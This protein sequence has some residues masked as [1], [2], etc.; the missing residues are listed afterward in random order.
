LAKS[1]GSLVPVF[2]ANF[3]RRKKVFSSVKEH[4]EREGE[5]RK[6]TTVYEHP[7][8]SIKT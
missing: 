3:L 5:A 2:P 8:T 4:L 7:H 6:L 1:A